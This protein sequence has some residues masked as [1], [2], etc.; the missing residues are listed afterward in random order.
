MMLQSGI[1]VQYSTL[2]HMITMVLVWGFVALELERSRSLQFDTHRR[3][4]IH[5][6]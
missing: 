1:T 6:M 5:V 3:G 4:A 2:L